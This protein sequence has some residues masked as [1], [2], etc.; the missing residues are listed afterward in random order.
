MT[1]STP[2][3]V[4]AFPTIEWLRQRAADRQPVIRA[5]ERT[6]PIRPSRADVLAGVLRPMLA[7]AVRIEER[8]WVATPDGELP[9]DLVLHV[10]GRRMALCCGPNWLEEQPDQDALCLVYGGFDALFRCRFDGTHDAAVDLA[11][12][13]MHHMPAAFSHFGRLSLGRRASQEVTH[14]LVESGSRPGSCL[15]TD[16]LSMRAMR[17]QVA[18]D[19]VRSFEQA[20]RGG[21]SLPLSA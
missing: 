4:S 1:S 18:S 13:L 17:L 3:R 21:Q 20:L 2:I 14:A 9:V 12:A 8:T 5:L 11:F 10:G 7:A 16:G 15:E 6:L 19:W